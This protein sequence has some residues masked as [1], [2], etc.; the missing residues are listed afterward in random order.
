MYLTPGGV[1]LT[2]G[3]F[4][5]AVKIAPR[6]P[7]ARW[8]RRG[9]DKVARMV[10]RPPRLNV[11]WNVRW[12]LGP[13]ADP[14][15]L[16]V[17]GSLVGYG[18]LAA[19]AWL[20]FDMAHLWFVWLALLNGPH[21]FAMYARTYLVPEERR[22][23]AALLGHS[24]WLF[25]I[26]PTVLAASAALAAG[27]VRWSRAPFIAYMVLVGLWAYWHVVRQHHGIV[28]LYQRRNGETSRADYWID[29]LLI[30][31][32]LTAPLLAFL[33][34]HP[35]LRAVLDAPRIADALAS[36][37]GGVRLASAVAAA[38]V[39]ALFV[40][41]QA[42]RWRAGLPLNAPKLVFLGAIVPFYLVLFFGQTAQAAP[43]FAVAP[44]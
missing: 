3:R 14:A 34:R 42:Q 32:G 26:G 6:S 33:C 15:L 43:L 20:R 35:D 18:L 2:V 4:C 44:L 22:S 11:R 28:R 23:R 12:I 31:V 21:L 16:T 39:I 27:G 37:A 36:V 1:P 40:L 8:F 5:P 13:R 9:R 30:H 24:L 7:V 41:R 17:G 25:A 19:Y 38:A 10:A 29:F